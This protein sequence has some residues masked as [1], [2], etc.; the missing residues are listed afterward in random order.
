MDRESVTSDAQ[1]IGLVFPVHHKSIP[2]IIK[3]FVGRMEGLGDRYLF[4]VCTHGDSP[5]LAIRDLGQV[6]ESRGGRLAAGFG[7][8]MPYNYLTPSPVLRGFFRSFRLRPVPRERQQ[9]LFAA[10]REKI[11]AIAAYVS[12]SESGHLETTSDI[13]TRLADRLNLPESLAKVVWLKVAGVDERPDLPFLESRQLM[14]RAFYADETC[15]GCG[16]CARICPVSNIKLVD[17]R[18]A[19][20][21]HCERC[22]ACL[23]WCPQ[24]AIQFGGET[25]G[26]SRYHHPDV[27]LAEMLRSSPKG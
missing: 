1:A 6:V 10:A 21:Q 27:T 25:A 8:H 9:A 17:G 26:G 18:P 13:L 14:D 3:R 20:Q 2:L 7:L 12:A 11:K 23:H 22:F 5:G 16:I 24:E 4:A 19:W 15:N